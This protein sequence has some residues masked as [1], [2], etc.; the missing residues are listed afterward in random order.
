MNIFFLHWNPQICAQYHVDKHVVKMILE[1]CQLLC[2]AWHML[3]PQHE[4]FSPPLKKTHFNHPCAKWA[5]ESK[6]NYLWLCELGLELCKEY[7]FRYEKTHKY[8]SLLV[9]LKT[10]VPCINEK[11]TIPS[12]CMPDE[13]KVFDSFIF[14]YRYYYVHGKKHIHKW[15]K[16]TVPFFCKHIKDITREGSSAQKH[17]FF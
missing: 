6:Q 11:L 15:K 10:K 1:S 2:T 13:Y 17:T 3:D 12:L 14:S 5:R 7:T 16:R 8:E 9:E 4:R